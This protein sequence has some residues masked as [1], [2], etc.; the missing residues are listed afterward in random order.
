MFNL[1]ALLP[2]C[3]LATQLSMFGR[4]YPHKYITFLSKMFLN[5]DLKIA[6]TCN[7]TRFMSLTYIKAAD[8]S[9]DVDL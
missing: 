6:N 2:M 8:L 1:S 5:L 9:V 7:A 4:K 3:H